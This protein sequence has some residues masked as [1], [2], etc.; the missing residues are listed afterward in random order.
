MNPAN[1]FVVFVLCQFSV[2]FLYVDNSFSWVFL[3]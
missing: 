2:A 1:A 3:I